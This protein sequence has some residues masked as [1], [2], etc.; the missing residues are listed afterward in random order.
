[1]QRHHAIDTLPG[2]LVIHHHEGRERPPALIMRKAAGELDGSPE[3]A[4]VTA[5]ELCSHLNRSA[6]S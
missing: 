1:M 3:V 5:I 2:D 4:A 6:R